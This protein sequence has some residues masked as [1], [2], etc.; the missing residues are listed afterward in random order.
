VG[1]V[2]TLSASSFQQSSVLSEC[3]DGIED[4]PLGAVEHQA[5]TK[6]AQD[7]VMNAEVGE[8]QAEQVLP[9][10]ARANRIGCLPVGQAF[11]KLEQRHQS[12]PY[13]RLGG[14]TL[15]GKDIGEVR[16]AEQHI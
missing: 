15:N 6:L 5:A 2:T 9:V 14:L 8:F 3:D 11:L 10:D 4:T 13:W 7:G 1:R 16:V 12:E